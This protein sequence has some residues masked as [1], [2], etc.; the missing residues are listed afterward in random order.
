MHVFGTQAVISASWHLA[1]QVSVVQYE[2]RGHLGLA[3]F[4]SSEGQGA[5]LARHCSYR[6]GTTMCLSSQRRHLTLL[7]RASYEFGLCRLLGTFYELLSFLGTLLTSF[8]TM[9]VYG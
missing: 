3:M 1:S 5:G 2:K 4:E 8:M 7:R 9:E 6:P